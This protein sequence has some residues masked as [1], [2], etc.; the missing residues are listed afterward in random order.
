MQRSCQFLQQKN[1]GA[2]LLLRRPR[3]S[4]SS[5]ASTTTSTTAAAATATTADVTTPSITDF[6]ARGVHWRS[7]QFSTFCVLNIPNKRYI[8]RIKIITF[9]TTRQAYIHNIYDMYNIIVLL[10]VN[11]IPLK[12]HVLRYSDNI[13]VW[14]GIMRKSRVTHI[15]TIEMNR[16][17]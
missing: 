1:A 13:D 3:T 12:C 4:S 16:K 8:L 9:I 10:Y 6:S 17:K 7:H 11:H 5:I 14:N 2:V 15:Y